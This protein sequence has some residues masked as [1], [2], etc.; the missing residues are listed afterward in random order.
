ME[1]YRQLHKNLNNLYGQMKR[2]YFS[3]RNVYFL[4]DL[5]KNLEN[6]QRSHQQKIEHYSSSKSYCRRPIGK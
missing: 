1:Y 2:E 3:K 4:G 6:Y 5:K